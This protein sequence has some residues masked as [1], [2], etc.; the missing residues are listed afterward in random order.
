[1]EKLVLKH[2]PDWPMTGFNGLFPSQVDELDS[3]GFDLIECF[4]FDY[5]QEFTHESWRGR[6]RTCNGV[7]S[8]KLTAAQVERFD[9]ELAAQLVELGLP[10]RFTVKHR[11]WGVLARRPVTPQGES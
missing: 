1:M 5:D 6:L 2:A 7:G 11:V 8:G 9:E 4:A 10:E 3:A